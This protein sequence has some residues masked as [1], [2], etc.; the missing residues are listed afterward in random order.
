MNEQK[1]HWL[2]HVLCAHHMH[3]T[4]RVQYFLSECYGKEGND[5]FS[6]GQS[7]HLKLTWSDKL[8]NEL[9]SYA[10]MCWEPEAWQHE[11]SLRCRGENLNTTSQCVTC[12]KSNNIV[13]F[14]ILCLCIIL[15]LGVYSAIPCFRIWGYILPFHVLRFG[16]IF[17]AL[18]HH[19]MF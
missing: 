18:F 9:H 1:Q 6:S 4:Y 19:S 14:C 8:R 10:Q 16:A 11:K 3:V 5:T 17:H 12:S 15:Y 13:Y 2:V 7:F